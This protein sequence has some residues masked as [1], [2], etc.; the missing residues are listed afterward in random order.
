MPPFAYHRPESVD[1]A[2][3]LLG[4]HGGE[5]KVLAGGQSL[6]PLLAM[7][8]AHP[9]HLVDIGDITELDSVSTEDDGTVVMGA[10]V[11]H[12]RAEESKEI[13][14]RAPLVAGAMPF[15]GHRAIRNRGTVCGSL[16][17]ADP[18]AEL[19]AVAVAVDAE[20]VVRRSSGERRVAAGDFFVGYLTSDLAEDELLTAVRFPA[21]PARAGWSVQEMSRRHGDFAVIGVVAVVVLDPD[22]AVE[23]AALSFFGAGER[24]VR[25][26]EAEDLLVGQRPEEALLAD[27]GKLVAD[28]LQPSGDN[29]GSGPYRSH[30]AG[31]LTR[32]SLA[33]ATQRAQGKEAA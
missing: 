11:R 14:Q 13:A 9:G 20:L 28:R 27:A 31:V 3:S 21:W 30:V 15:I 26:G 23:R 17:H 22:G 18:A 16:A 4:N 24:P 7:R 12:S 10:G 8:L 2:L 1:E 25:V 6:L 32:R 33:E 19:P 5:A 29:H